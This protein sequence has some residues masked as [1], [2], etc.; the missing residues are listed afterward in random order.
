VGRDG[1]HLGW[2]PGHTAAY[3]SHPTFRVNLTGSVST[4]ALTPRASFPRLRHRWLHLSS[5]AA[6]FAATTGEARRWPWRSGLELHM[7]HAGDGREFTQGS[8]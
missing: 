8:G 1:R 5:A 6:S 4:R 2:S 7:Q 3:V